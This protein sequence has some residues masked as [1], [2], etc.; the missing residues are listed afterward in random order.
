M[1]FVKL[2]TAA[3]VMT[4]VLGAA[5]FAQPGGTAQGHGMSGMDMGTMMNRCAKMRQ[6]VHQGVTLS[7]DMQ[8]MMTRCD[9]MD[10][11]MGGTSAS[12]PPATHNR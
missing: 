2:C 10:R 1:K 12:A 4:L 6:E 3:T 5:A 8:K 7:P 11:Q 9:Q